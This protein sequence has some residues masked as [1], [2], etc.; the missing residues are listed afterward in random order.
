MSIPPTEPQYST[1]GS[2][3]FQPRPRA[4]LTALA[5]LVAIAI[6]AM[7]LWWLM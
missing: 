2:P 1:S 4:A 5:I 6:I 7:L 3:R